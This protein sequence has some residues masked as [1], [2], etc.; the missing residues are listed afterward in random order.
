MWQD[1]TTA[2]PTW[3]TDKTAEPISQPIFQFIHYCHSTNTIKHQKHKSRDQFMIRDNYLMQALSWKWNNSASQEYSSCN[4]IWTYI[5][6]FTKAHQ[7]TLS[8]AS[9][10]Q[11]PNLNSITQRIILILLMALYPMWP[12]PLLITIK[13]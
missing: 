10:I 7:W 4:T 3:R 13:N 2:M 11:S 5:T 1:M 12:F 8:R 6:T 9:S